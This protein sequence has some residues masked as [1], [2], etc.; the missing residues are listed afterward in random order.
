L[1]SLPDPELKSASQT[2]ASPRKS[3]REAQFELRE[4][5]ILDAT[6]RLLA[7][8]GYEAMSMDDIAAEVGVAKGSLYKHFESKDALAA[9]VMTRL[10]LQTRQ[11]LAAQPAGTA[12]IDRLKAVLRWTLERRLAGGVPHLPS[13]SPLLQQSLLSNS[14]YV[15]TLMSLS[16]DI[17]RLIREARAAGAL[18]ASLREEFVLY[19]L[20]ARTCDPTLDFL[21]DGGSMS[22][23]EI[24][25]QMVSAC[26]D[27]LAG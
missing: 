22:D 23:A 7:D 13:T 5:A 1:P 10:L 25:E 19:S 17:G 12:P 16:E 6:N 4:E 8:K 11:A 18:R 3:F 26:F 20:Y 9:A 15:Q 21:K 14:T 2:V 24:V 27:G